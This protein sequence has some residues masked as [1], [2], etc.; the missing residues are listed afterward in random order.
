MI[1][2]GSASHP[3]RRKRENEDYHAYFPPEEGW[4]NKKGI[5][6]ALADG[7]GGRSGGAIA[8][9]VAVEALM[10]AYYKDYF[11]NIPKSLEKA[12]L[13]DNEVVIDRGQ[14]DAKLKGM[15]TTLTAVVLKN[16]K[17]FYAHVGD[18]RG[19]TIYGENIR[20]RS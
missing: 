14:K 10:E 3:G 11:T 13:K 18:S 9:K 8:S 5:L 2:I 6:I 17:M 16:G 4:K 12:F 1:T 15:A 20:K 7:M 19:Y